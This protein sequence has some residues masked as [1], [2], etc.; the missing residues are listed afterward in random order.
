MFPPWPFG[1]VPVQAAESCGFGGHFISMQPQ[2]SHKRDF[3]QR[4]RSWCISP[5]SWAEIPT[6][7]YSASC[8]RSSLPKAPSPT[9]WVFILPQSEPS[10]DWR[11]WR[12][13][14][15]SLSPIQSRGSQGQRGHT[16]HTQLSGLCCFS[17]PPCR[18]LRHRCMTHCP[19]LTLSWWNFESV[20]QSCL[21]SGWWSWPEVLLGWS[22]TGS[23]LRPGPDVWLKTPA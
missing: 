6:C 8:F 17:W 5:V 9:P 14:I 10:S 3:C 21:P 20:T 11:G 13:E 15:N 12:L 7:C 4:H 1:C 16:H 22:T 23:D 2:Q 19:T 18:H